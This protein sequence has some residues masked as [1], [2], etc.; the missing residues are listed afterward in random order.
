MHL[1]L[2]QARQLAG[3]CL[4]S[5]HT[6]SRHVLGRQRLR[7]FTVLARAATSEAQP[8]GRRRS[9]AQSLQVEQLFSLGREVFDTALQT[10]PK[11][12]ARSI[13]A[14]GAFA[15]IGR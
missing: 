9:Q 10:G 5:C 4:H 11:G 6:T 1:Q 13:Q 2:L 7:K 14:A 3:P 8:Q 12:F 15:S